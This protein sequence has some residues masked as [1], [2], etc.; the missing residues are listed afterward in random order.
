M[1]AYN[2]GNAEGTLFWNNSD[3]LRIRQSIFKK[4]RKVVVQNVQQM[5]FLIGDM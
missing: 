2:G 3:D 4:K 5:C 1:H